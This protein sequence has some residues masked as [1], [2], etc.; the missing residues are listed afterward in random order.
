MHNYTFQQGFF[1]VVILELA[2][3]VYE[4]I[5]F[6]HYLQH[7]HERHE[8]QRFSCVR[9]C[10]FIGK[11][12]VIKYHLFLS[13]NRVSISQQ[14]V[15]LVPP[16]LA[17]LAT[18]SQYTVCSEY[19]KLNSFC[20]AVEKSECA[21]KSCSKLPFKLV[22]Y[23]VLCLPHQVKMQYLYFRFQANYFLLP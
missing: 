23:I 21:E 8:L 18:N 2:K 22:I 1:C 4:E 15:P 13:N 9:V 7:S 5:L 10:G 20:I 14:H 19:G 17:I 16:S 6:R 11:S 12:V 3:G